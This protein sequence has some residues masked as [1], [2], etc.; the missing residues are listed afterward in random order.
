MRVLS[1]V[2]GVE[3]DLMHLMP[4]FV[5]KSTSNDVHRGFHVINRPWSMLQF[6]NSPRWGARRLFEKDEDQTNASLSVHPPKGEVGRRRATRKVHQNI[7]STLSALCP[8]AICLART[9]SAAH[10]GQTK[11][12]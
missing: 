9:S 7:P 8:S 5:A 11:G 4:T 6:V 10:A 3:D 2:N 12:V 1:S